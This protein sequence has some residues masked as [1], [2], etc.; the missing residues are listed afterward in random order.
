M[1]VDY[2]QKNNINCNKKSLHNI[3]DD[4]KS[5]ISQLKSKN[6]IG[7]DRKVDN[8]LDSNINKCKNGKDKEKIEKKEYKLFNK[9]YSQVRRYKL[10]STINPRPEYLLS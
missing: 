5:N 9:N 3:I 2:N 10:A 8:L 4:D 6:I 1:Q 7:N